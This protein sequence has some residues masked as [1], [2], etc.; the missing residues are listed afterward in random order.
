MQTGS[1]GGGAGASGGES[2]ERWSCDYACNDQTSG[3]RDDAAASALCS[4]SSCTTWSRSRMWYRVAGPPADAPALE[5]PRPLLRTSPLPE[6]LPVIAAAH[7]AT[8]RCRNH[9]SCHDNPVAKGHSLV[10]TLFDYTL[11][12]LHQESPGFVNLLMQATIDIE[13]S[14]MSSYRS[15]DEHFH[16]SNPMTVRQAPFG[17]TTMLPTGTGAKGSCSTGAGQGHR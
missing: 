13:S 7:S 15:P 16:P 11:C 8:C 5:D 10:I 14:S 3:M 9:S 4:S 2:C 12:P 17:V 1:E 6:Q